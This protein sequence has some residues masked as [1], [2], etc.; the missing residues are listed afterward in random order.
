MDKIYFDELS[1]SG[2]E[3]SK[4][5]PSQIA[6]RFA[7]YKRHRS[8]P[9][10]GWMYSDAAIADKD[11][12]RKESVYKKARENFKAAASKSNKEE[13]EQWKAEY[14]ETAAKLSAIEKLREQDED[15]ADE[16]MD[17]LENTPEYDRYLIMKDYN[18][19]MND[20]TKA[21]LNSKSPTERE[22]LTKAMFKVQQE[23][24]NELKTSK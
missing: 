15:E 6:E 18:S 1:A 8:A 4:M 13:L 21:W 10:T 9:L 24:V 7:R 17:A 20:I 12:K 5:T 2:V 23:M 14:K 22:Q 3:A 11:G 19:D 16:Q